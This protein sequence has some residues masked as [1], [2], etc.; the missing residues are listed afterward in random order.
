M[1]VVGGDGR[2]CLGPVFAGLEKEAGAP[3]AAG[4]DWRRW[5]C[6]SSPRGGSWRRWKRRRRDR[7]LRGAAAAGLPFVPAARAPRG[8]PPRRAPRPRAPARGPNRRA[9]AAP[10]MRVPGPAAPPGC[11]RAMELSMKKFTVRRFFSVYLRRKSRSKSSSLGRLEV[12]APVRAGSGSAPRAAPGDA[13]GGRRPSEPCPL[14]HARRPPHRRLPAGPSAEVVGEL[15]RF[16]SDPRVLLGLGD[17]GTGRGPGRNRASPRCSVRRA[18]RFLGGAPRKPRV[19]DLPAR[20]CAVRVGL[21]DRRPEPHKAPRVVPMD[22]GGFESGE[23]AQERMGAQP[24]QPGGR[25]RA[26]MQYPGRCGAETHSRDRTGRACPS[27]V[28]AP[29]PPLWSSGSQSSVDASPMCFYSTTQSYS[30][31]PRVHIALLNL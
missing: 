23:R 15:V 28:P 21:C 30:L 31:Q 11:A 25:P 10:G 13:A 22:L 1:A 5:S 16:P 20:P 2:G 17:H 6:R 8:W 3:G 9:G 29:V 19:Q 4:V 12:T 24:H 18:G 14:S 7:W 26:L 27:P